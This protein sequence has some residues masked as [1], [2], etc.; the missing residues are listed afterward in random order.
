[1]P[2]SYRILPPFAIGASNG[3]PKIVVSDLASSSPAAYA[4]LAMSAVVGA[5]LVPSAAGA[6]RPPVVVQAAVPLTL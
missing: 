3:L 1:M 6:A 4:P 2:L 5:P